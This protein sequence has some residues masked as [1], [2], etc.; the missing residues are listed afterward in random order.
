DREGSAQAG[1]RGAFDDARVRFAI[2]GA[3]AIGAYVGAALSRGGSHVTLI[4]RGDHLR[5]MQE[6]GVQVQSPRGDFHAHPDATDDLDAMAD[7]D[8]VFIGLKAHSLPE[9]APRIGRALR[10]GAAVIGAQ[11]GLPWWYFQSQPG[12]LENA[13]LESVDPG[14]TIAASIPP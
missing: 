1:R 7:A 10:P 5:A 6:R 9:L 3:G 14:G 2:L 11:N 4:A 8:A 12:P 13:V